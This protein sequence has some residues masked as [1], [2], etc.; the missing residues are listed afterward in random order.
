MVVVVTV[1]IVA[2][3]GGGDRLFELLD[4]VGEEGGSESTG[5]G[6]LACLDIGV[7]SLIKMERTG[8][9]VT[10]SFWVAMVWSVLTCTLTL[11]PT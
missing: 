6:E 2:R 10:E 8:N 9:L 7:R 4:L 5:H 11:S 3:R 1:V